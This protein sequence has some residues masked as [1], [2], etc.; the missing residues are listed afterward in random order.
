MGQF[1]IAPAI[2]SMSHDQSTAK[3]DHLLADIGGVIRYPIDSFH[4][5][6]QAEGEAGAERAG[7]NLIFG[8]LFGFIFKSRRSKTISKRRSR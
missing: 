2:G 3:I 7:C 1:G 6:K 8:T 5:A 4:H